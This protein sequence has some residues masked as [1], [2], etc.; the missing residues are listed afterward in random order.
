MAVDFFKRGFLPRRRRARV[1]P[2]LKFLKTAP[3]P[4]RRLSGKFPLKR[5]PAMIAGCVWNTRPFFHQTAIFP[6]D[7]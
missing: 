3:Q 5:E 1:S 4:R 7:V 2:P 6:A